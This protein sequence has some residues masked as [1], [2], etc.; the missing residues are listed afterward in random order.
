MKAISLLAL[1]TAC[2]S[3]TLPQIPD[4]VNRTQEQLEA[5]K[6]DADVNRK[7]HTQNT[8][9]IPALQ[10]GNYVANGFHNCFRTDAQIYEFLD[11]LVKL[12]PDV[13]T[14]F[15]VGTTFKKQT[16]YGY[17]IVAN[18]A[19]PPT[20][21][22]Y[23][24][25]L[26][27][28]REWI[29][30]SSNLYAISALLDDINNGKVKDTLLESYAYYTVPVL[31]IDGYQLSW[32]GNRYQRKNAN[33][34]DLNRNWPGPYDDPDPPSP[35]DETYPGPYPWSEPET[36][37]VGTWL[38]GKKGEIAGLIDLHSNAGSV[39]VP[40]G[41]T[42]SPLPGDTDDRLKKLGDA[43]ASA[44]GG[45]YDVG[46]SYDILGYM[47]YHGTRDWG[48]RNLDKP[49]LTVE[50]T[51]VDFVVPADTIRAR[52]KELYQGLQA[53]GKQCTIYNGG[54]TPAPTSGTPTMT[55]TTPKPAC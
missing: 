37:T 6:D 54:T 40:V 16:I 36:K 39:L 35:S 45:G 32:T 9:Y 18:P 14:K 48:F 1:V 51:G 29:T 15:P 23:L 55:P 22:L 19:K 25:S 10:K 50:M 17:K 3:A 5:I 46:R 7:C 38:T 28:A 42:T 12:N 8:N 30:G 31:N 44:M 26:I 20:Q 43:L 52:G 41:D 21:A 24:Q 34:V 27:H 4:G 47:V 2:V 49:T 33:G 53:Y 13:V 11:A